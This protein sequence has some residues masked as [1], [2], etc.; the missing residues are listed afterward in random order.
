MSEPHQPH[1]LAHDAA[2]VVHEVAE[3]AKRSAPK[4]ILIACIAAL[5][6]LGGLLAAMRYGVLLPQ[7]RLLIQ[8]A[9]NGLKVGRFGRL[10]IEGLTGDIWSDLRIGK[11]T[12]RDE[13][14]VW[15]EADNVRLRWR[16]L[17]LLRRNFQAD[18]IEVGDLKLI[19]RPSLSAAGGQD[20]G[21]PVSF[22]IDHAHGRLELMPGFSYQRGVYDLDFNLH[23]ARTGGMSARVRAASV[24]RP[25][26]HLNLDYDIEP[27][28]PLVV[29]VDAVE[30]RGGARAG[31][32][33]LPANLPFALKVAASGR[34]AGGRFTA[35]A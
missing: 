25:G 16:Y 27:K 18:D 17:E 6:G 19:R 7:A 8:A 32:I 9:T 22:H 29:Q 20:T 12:L 28:K 23:V 35:A 1:D 33:G 15:L 14:G 31:A 21:L 30:A 5:V 3:A 34:M 24:L 13:Q 11:L 26:D 10:N 2:E 4:L